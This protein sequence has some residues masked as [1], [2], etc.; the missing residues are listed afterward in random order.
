MNTGKIFV[1]PFASLLDAEVDAECEGHEAESYE[2]RYRG[3]GASEHARE[4]LVY[5]QSHCFLV[6]VG[7]PELFIV[8]V[9]EEYRIVHSY[10]ELEDCR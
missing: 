8:A 6:V 5:R 7:Y 9:P 3:H 10:R 1:T 2:A 4:R